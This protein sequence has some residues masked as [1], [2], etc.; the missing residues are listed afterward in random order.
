MVEDEL[1][2]EAGSDPHA[3]YESRPTSELVAL[4]NGEDS[5]VPGAVAAA[6][7]AI[8]DA[9]DAVA[10]RMQAGGRLVYVGAGSSGL[11]AALDAS[12]C[13]ATFST[14]AGLVVAVVA[15]GTAAAPLARAAAEDDREAGGR[16][17]GVLDVRPEDAVVGVSASGSTPYVAG[18][19]E[20]ATAAGA[21]TVCVVCAPGS[22]LGS[23]VDHEIVVV[24]GPEFI[25]GST[26]L[27]AGTAQKLVL[28][29]IS[30]IAMIRLGKTYGNL[31]VDVVAVN[32]KLVG[33]VRRIVAA[34]TGAS[35]V[36]IDDALA[37][38]NGDARVAIVSLVANVD[39]DTARGRLTASGRSIAGA[40]EDVE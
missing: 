3:G 14:P 36:E 6:A 30:T 28:N 31:M 5:T 9:I 32:E 40:L 18:A 8:A 23:L 38:A 1:I 39:A 10:D 12:E 20:A 11:I 33:R 13:E 17:L 26:R 24:V 21:L 4:M 7:P 15:G 29:A 35:P 25:A 19:L 16:D 22:T 34:A 2:T 37:A 27:K